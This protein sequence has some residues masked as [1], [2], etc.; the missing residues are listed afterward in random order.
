MQAGEPWRLMGFP[1]VINDGTPAIA[2]DSLSVWLGDFKQA[3]AV[4]R[5]PGIKLLRDPY[6]AKGQVKFYA[7]ARVGGDLINSEAIKAVKFA[8]A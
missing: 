1:V 7:Y 5:Q 6:T 2:A 4:V 3:Y 8:A